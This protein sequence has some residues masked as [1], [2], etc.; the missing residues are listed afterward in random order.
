MPDAR[1]HMFANEASK[2]QGLRDIETLH[3]SVFEEIDSSGRR[4]KFYQWQDVSRTIESL[5]IDR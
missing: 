2:L 5:D 1:Q 4:R 3:L